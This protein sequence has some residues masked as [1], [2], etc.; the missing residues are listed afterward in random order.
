M[1]TPAMSASST[2]VPEVIR[3]NAVST[4][5]SVPPFL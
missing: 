4:Q 2:S 1:F 5:V 3:R